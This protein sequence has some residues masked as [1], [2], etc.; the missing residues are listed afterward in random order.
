MSCASLRSVV[1]LVSGEVTA[2]FREAGDDILSSPV[3]IVL[4]CSATAPASS[5]L[6][7]VTNDSGFALHSAS[8]DARL[9]W[10]LRS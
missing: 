2:R 3:R 8:N 6:E 9:L 10:A 4:D 5:P 7:V 1:L